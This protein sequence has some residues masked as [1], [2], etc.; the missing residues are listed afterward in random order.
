M[1]MVGGV[2]FKVHALSA[3]G[4]LAA[5]EQELG[6]NDRGSGNILIGTCTEMRYKRLPDGPSEMEGSSDAAAEMKEFY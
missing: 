1:R 4:W 2:S 6:S 3:A 5:S